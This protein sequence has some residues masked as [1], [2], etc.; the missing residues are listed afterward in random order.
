VGDVS[1]KGASAALLMAAS[2]SLFNS[3]SFSHLRPGEL[4]ATLDQALVPYTKPRRQNCALC[5]VELTISPSSSEGPEKSGIIRIANAGC[6]P[7]YIRRGD[8]LEQPVIGGFALGQGLGSE[9]GYQEISLDL[10]ERDIIILVSDGVVEATNSSGEMFGFERLNEALVTGPQT[11]AAAMLNHLK[12]TLSTFVGE[13]EP[14]DD[15][16][17]IVAQL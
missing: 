15:M 11:S 16:T 14:H 5:Y 6:I 4:L 8:K 3:T 17:I 7:P 13:T 1:G 9:L 2:L 12:V 10:S